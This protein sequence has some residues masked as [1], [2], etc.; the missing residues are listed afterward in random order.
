MRC[1][2]DA[3]RQP[4]AEP[5]KKKSGERH[6]CCLP[7]H[8]HGTHTNT[9]HT[10]SPSASTLVTTR[11]LPS[12][13]SVFSWPL[14]VWV[15]VCASAKW[16]FTAR[17]PLH[18]LLQPQSVEVSSGSLPHRPPPET[19]AVFGISSTICGAQVSDQ[20]RRQ[21]LHM[22]LCALPVRPGHILTQRVPGGAWNHGTF[23]N[24]KERLYTVYGCPR[25]RLVP[26]Y[27]FPLVYEKCGS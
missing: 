6:V 22:C 14:I 18:E 4:N 13:L 17:P 1:G 19:R 26:L 8:R 24:H 10:H 11:F 16:G 12:A 2:S 23:R 21:A 7:S 20:L 27:P 3:V 9:E 25:R 5:D 15:L